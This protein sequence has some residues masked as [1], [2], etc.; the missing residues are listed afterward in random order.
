MM[1]VYSS[2]EA[3]RKDLRFE[4]HAVTEPS[5]EPKLE[6]EGCPATVYLGQGS[7]QPLLP[8]EDDGTYPSR[9]WHTL[10]ARL[11]ER[12]V[13]YHQRQTGCLLPG[14][15]SVFGRLTN[16]EP[17]RPFDPCGQPST[18][19]SRRYVHFESSAPVA[20]VA[21]ALREAVPKP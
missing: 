4:Y 14:T 1:A 2:L 11:G 21:A 16:E 7:R 13:C 9:L 3:V 20:D 10:Q 17:G 5:R 19:L 15:G 8:V 18:R 12:C 6:I